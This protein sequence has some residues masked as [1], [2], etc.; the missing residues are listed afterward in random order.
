MIVINRQPL[1]LA[2]VAEY[3]AKQENANATNDYLKEF[4]KRTKEESE[5]LA[6]EIRALNNI[7][8]KEESIIKIVD[9]DPKDSEDINKIFTEV[10]LSEEEINAILA[11]TKKY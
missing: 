8:I 3:V 11:I 4:N 1:T 9:L 10:S 2:Q 6:A 7:K 5:K